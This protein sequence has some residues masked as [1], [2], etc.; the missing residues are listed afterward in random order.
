MPRTAIGAKTSLTDGWSRNRLL[1]ILASAGIV[2][3][4]LVAGF[5]YAV[6]LA[7]HSAV[8]GTSPGEQP[9]LTSQQMNSDTALGEEHRDQIA[10]QP[11]LTVDADAMKPTTPTTQLAKPIRIPEA[12]ITG[13]D[14]VPT[15][16]PHTPEGAIGQL[17]ALS[18]TVIGAMSV[19]TAHHVYDDWA[20][21]GGAGA[22][23]WQMTAN[24]TSFL[25]AAGMGPTMSPGATVFAIPAAAQV[26]GTDGPDWTVACVLFEVDATISS[27]SSIGY[28]TCER[29]QWNPDS[30]SDN[31]AGGRWMIAP[32]APPIPAPNTWPG[33]ALALKAGWLTWTTTPAAVH[34]DNAAVNAPDNP[35]GDGA[36]TTGDTTAN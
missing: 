25:G 13:P 10:A 1:A 22:D 3:L 34:T 16:F 29:M 35:S 2:A 26:K 33:S 12:T 32:G 24:V 20:M 19:A 36:G 8:N 5:G 31:P 21:P 18:Q 23:S 6:Y 28:G 14:G 7:I 4:F 27:Q 17:A 11:M 15:G 30:G 9:T